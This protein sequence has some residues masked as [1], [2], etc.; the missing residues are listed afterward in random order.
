MRDLDLN[1]YYNDCIV[2]QMS[3]NHQNMKQHVI[4]PIFR[5]IHPSHQ[6]NEIMDPNYIPNGEES[7]YDDPSVAGTYSANYEAISQNSH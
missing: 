5:V 7:S 1:T 2:P 6:E 4:K 3:G